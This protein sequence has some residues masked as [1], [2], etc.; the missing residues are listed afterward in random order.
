MGSHL[1]RPRNALS[2][3]PFCQ[4]LLVRRGRWCNKPKPLLKVFV[5]RDVGVAD[6]SWSQMTELDLAYGQARVKAVGT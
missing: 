3:V 5:N 6:A 4:Q 2:V 1:D